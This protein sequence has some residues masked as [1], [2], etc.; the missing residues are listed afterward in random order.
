M[1]FSNHFL[2]GR[3]IKMKSKLIMLIILSTSFLHAGGVSPLC[4]A[5]SGQGTLENNCYLL[6]EGKNISNIEAVGSTII[7]RNKLTPAR[8]IQYVGTDA[9][10][11]NRALSILLSA[12]STGSDV[13]IYIAS[14]NWDSG[15]STS[16]INFSNVLIP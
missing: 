7:F 15:S 11:G 10:F 5:T 16:S 6:I 12:K 2:K 9:V 1:K 13:M 14:G 4:R 8:D 3:N